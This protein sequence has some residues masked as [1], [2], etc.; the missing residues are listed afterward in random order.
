MPKKKDVTTML[1]RDVP[2][3]VSERIRRFCKEEGIKRREFVERAIDRLE[4]ANQEHGKD[5]GQGDRAKEEAN[6]M[7]RVAEITEKVKVYKNAIR[8]KKDLIAISESLPF[9]ADRELQPHLYLEVNAMEKELA[10][11]MEKS[12]PRYDI[13]DDPEKRKAM[14]LPDG[15]LSLYIVPRKEAE[16]VKRHNEEADRRWKMSSEP[17]HIPSAEELREKMEKLKREF[18]GEN[19]TGGVKPNEG[20]SKTLTKQDRVQ[21]GVAASA[22]PFQKP[23]ANEAEAEPG[24]EQVKTTRFGRGFDDWIKGTEGDE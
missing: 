9:L 4:G 2:L 20:S 14:G 1:M 12:I 18:R 8:L 11:I 17:K 13:P 24:K 19:M 6:P 23:P 21:F 15:G 5:S 7:D 16:E 10:D 3:D 22:G